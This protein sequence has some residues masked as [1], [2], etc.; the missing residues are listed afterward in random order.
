MSEPIPFEREL[1][2]LQ[3]AQEAVNEAT[4][5]VVTELGHLTVRAAEY[6]TKADVAAVQLGD[7]AE[8]YLQGGVA[9]GTEDYLVAYELYNASGMKEHAYQYELKK[10]KTIQEQDAVRKA[11]GIDTEGS[12]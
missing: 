2:Y 5:P 7:D 8:I 11:Y 1:Q 10:A 6:I 12:G 9:T 3:I 4:E